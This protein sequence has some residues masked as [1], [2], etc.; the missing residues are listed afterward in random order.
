MVGS[1]F[2]VTATVSTP[3]YVASG[4][5]VEP[6]SIP[7]GVT[8]LDVQTTRLDG[9]TMSFL[10]VPDA[11]TLGNV[12]SGAEPI[13]DLELQGGHARPQDLQD[14]GVVGERGRGHR[15]HDGRRSCRPCPTWWKPR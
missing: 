4:V 6:T 9:V 14:T 1:T 10:A 15:D 11:L 12:V 5:Q 8:L 2:A 13:G 3:S 7:L